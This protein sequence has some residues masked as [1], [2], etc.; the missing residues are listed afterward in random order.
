M[1]ACASEL[2]APARRHHTASN[3]WTYSAT[4]PWRQRISDERSN[5][6]ACW[7]DSSR[8]PQVDDVYSGAFAVSDYLVSWALERLGGG[9][10][11]GGGN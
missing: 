11:P 5:T 1:M 3:G 2:R 7:K 10:A 8:R 9:R 6:N 4:W